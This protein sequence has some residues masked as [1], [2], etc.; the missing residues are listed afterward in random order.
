MPIGGTLF[1]GGGIST[2]KV[3]LGLELTTLQ[4]KHA[5]LITDKPP[6]HMYNM[7]YQNI[8]SSGLNCCILPKHPISFSQ[9]HLT[10]VKHYKPILS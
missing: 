1:P 9:K 10:K 3:L 8:S 2:A 5:L 7:Y 4:I 6:Q